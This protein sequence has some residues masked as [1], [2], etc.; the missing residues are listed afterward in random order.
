MILNIELSDNR[1]AEAWVNHWQAIK[2]QGVKLS[3]LINDEGLGMKAAK[4]IELADIDRQSDTFHAVA[5]RLG[6]YS[7]RLLSIAYKAIKQEE[8]YE[9]AK[10][11]AKEAIELYDN[12]VFLYHCLLECFQAFDKQGNLKN[13]EEVKLDFDR[14]NV[15][16]PT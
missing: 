12:F 15:R 1:K 5:H 13:I 9:S 7:N 3:M 4:E 2:S 6:M 8:K 10:A 14:N 16:K 11:N